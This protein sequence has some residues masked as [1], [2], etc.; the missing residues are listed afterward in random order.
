VEAL[1]LA[2]KPGGGGRIREIADYMTEISGPIDVDPGAAHELSAILT[3]DGSYLWDIGKACF[4]T[5]GVSSGS[6]ARG[7]SPR[8]TSASSAES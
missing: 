2:K 7:P 3:D 4:P 8:S 6:L 5:P 1:R